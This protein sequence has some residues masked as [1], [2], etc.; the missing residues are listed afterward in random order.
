MIAAPVSGDVIRLG[1][2][3]D[4]AP[5]NYLNDDGEMRGFEADLAALICAQASL[6]CEWVLQPSDESILAL[7]TND[8]DVIMTGMQITA[9]RD[10]VIDFSQEYF[11]ADPSAFMTL[12]GGNAPAAGDV[13]GTQTGTLQQSYATENG[14]AVHL[15]DSLNDVVAALAAGEVTVILADQAY[16]ET[17]VAATPDTYA[18]V[19]TDISTGGGVGLGVR[20]TSPV[21]LSQL[22]AALTSL[23]SSGSLDALIGSWFEGRDPNYRGQ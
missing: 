15:Y 14:Y 4:Y 7:T 5:Y 21:L 1:S 12:T 19:A 17:V 3:A 8:I 9:E 23:K 16:L 11:P 22:D 10:L 6:E 13:I 18:L 20:E 2:V